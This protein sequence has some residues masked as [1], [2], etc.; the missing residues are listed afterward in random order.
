MSSRAR[1]RRRNTTRAR[2]PI[3]RAGCA[4]ALRT[5]CFDSSCLS[6]FGSS[7][8]GSRG[9][10]LPEPAALGALI[11]FGVL[12]ALALF[13]VLLAAPRALA[14]CRATT[15]E[16]G[17]V[18]CDP[19][20]PED[21]GEPLRWERTC[22][23]LSM[24]EDGS[25]R[26]PFDEA[27]A[28]LKAAMKTW[29]TAD[30]GDGTTPGLRLRDLGPVACDEVEYNGSAGN[31]NIV[32]FRDSRWPH[33]NGPH[34]IALTTVTYDTKSGAVYD[35]DIEINTAQYD[36]TTTDVT[37]DYDLQS[38][39]T[40]EIGHLLG[41]AHSQDDDAT[42]FSVYTAGTTAFRT[43]SDDDRAAMCK[44]YPPKN[45]PKSCNPIPRHGFSPECRANQ[46]EGDC[47]VRAAPLGTSRG[48]LAAL[49]ALSLALLARRSRFR[50]ETHGAPRSKRS[51][52]CIGT[53]LQQSVLRGVTFRARRRAR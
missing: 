36:L 43:L 29:E 14:Y 13:A 52:K 37:S 35:A 49:G 5:P 39:F 12:P 33:P 44:V 48:A 3:T 38:I 28:A 45:L 27:R 21:C 9:S 6:S 18:E 53:R 32:M 40:H 15:C 2:A 41:F 1:S 20:T 17:G 31:A 42:M 8:S 24:Q 34:N 10:R 11:A 51:S 19:P 23:G 30:C 26:I 16:P 50:P 22:V 47:A 7:T 25:K 46:T 4:S